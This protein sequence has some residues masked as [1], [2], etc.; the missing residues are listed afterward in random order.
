MSTDLCK[1]KE[2]HVNSNFKVTEK[3]GRLCSVG[4]RKVTAASQY[5]SCTMF[6]ASLGW[7][8]SRQV[9]LNI[10]TI[11]SF[12]EMEKTVGLSNYMLMMLH[13]DKGCDATD[14]FGKC[15]ML[16]SHLNSLLPSCCIFLPKRLI[17]VTQIL[18]PL[19]P[20]HSLDGACCLFQCVP[21]LSEFAVDT[22]I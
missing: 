6:T 7:L 21:Q 2:C 19:I 11:T 14:D 4:S 22:F 16:L 3:W 17:L 18:Q 1:P 5:V 20:F 12:G 13:K 10:D 8:A 15:Y 9:T